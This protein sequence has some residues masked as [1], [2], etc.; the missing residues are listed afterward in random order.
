MNVPL[1]RN[2]ISQSNCSQSYETEINRIFQRPIFQLHIKDGTQNYVRHHNTQTHNDRHR[3]LFS[4]RG[5]CS[6]SRPQKSQAAAVSKRDQI[7]WIRNNLL[8]NQLAC[9]FLDLLCQF[10]KIQH[11]FPCFPPFCDGPYTIDNISDYKYIS[12][13]WPSTRQ[14]WPKIPSWLGGRSLRKRGQIN[15]P[16]PQCVRIL[17]SKEAVITFT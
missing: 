13:H 5:C 14:C 15:D 10:S 1:T 9:R 7:P 3:D 17:H 2:Q 4:K 12:R 6:K 8:P 16:R 11:P